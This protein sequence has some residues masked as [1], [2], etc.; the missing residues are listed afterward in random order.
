MRIRTSPTPFQ[1]ITERLRAELP[2]AGFEPLPPGFS[3]A[4]TYHPRADLEAGAWSW[5]LLGPGG[6]LLN[7]GSQWSARDLLRYRK[8]EISRNDHGELD[9]DPD[10]A[11]LAGV[12]ARR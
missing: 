7:I 1:R 8:W 9:I 3:A 2:A 5:H 11:E 12:G 6:E 4:R 10:P